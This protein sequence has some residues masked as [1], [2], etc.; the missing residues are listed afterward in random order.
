ME[1]QKAISLLMY[2]EEKYS[3]FNYEY[4][5]WSVWRLLR[6]RYFSEIVSFNVRVERQLRYYNLIR[7]PFYTVQL[8]FA[9]LWAKKDQLFLKTYR[10]AFRGSPGGESRD[11]FYGYIREKYEK[12][13]CLEQVNSRHYGTQR[14]RL[15]HKPLAATEP[16]DFLAYLLS[17][18]TRDS[19]LDT[20]VDEILDLIQNEDNIPVLE[21][22]S[23]KRNMRR[24]KI[25][26]RIYGLLFK[27]LK[28]KAVFVADAGD[29]PMLIAARNYGVPFIELQ[30]GVF[31]EM[32]PDN[33]PSSAENDK[34]DLLIPDYFL[35]FGE[36]W[37]NQL[38]NSAYKKRHTVA[39]GIQDV[40]HFRNSIRKRTENQE[41]PVFLFTSQGHH[42]DAC[43][44][45]L[46]Q[47]FSDEGRDCKL[48]VKL[49]PY[50]HTDRNKF[51]KLAAFVDLEIL[52]QRDNRNIFELISIC[53][54]HLSISS[55]CH[56]DSASL[57]K[58]SI[59]MPLPGREHMTDFIDNQMIFE[60]NE[61][62]SIFAVTS[63]MQNFSGADT[64]KLAEEYVASD[65]EQNVDRFLT[66]L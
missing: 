37:L 24:M 62:E 3:L 58:P 19:R 17:R 59:V 66:S 45:W 52:D 49:H 11:I 26:A 35:S 46:Y 28:P 2:I 56:F 34:T 32:H 57:G 43:V 55:A 40:D 5:G 10:T 41:S 4:N 47:Q 18:F 42:T 27:W 54:F 14:S 12:A 22:S 13:F 25:E 44:D 60:I 7:L 38:E 1:P 31:G 61:E 15:K 51:E 16:I 8:L 50:Y 48:I 33:I 36:F 30:H 53:D 29:Y 39:I 63:K 20:A 21:S 23:L 6:T 64:S 65:Y 9:L